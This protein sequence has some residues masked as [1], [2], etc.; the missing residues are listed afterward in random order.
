MKPLQALESQLDARSRREKILLYIALILGIYFCIFHSFFADSLEQ[1][2]Q[3]QHNIK[4]SQIYLQSNKTQNIAKDLASLQET[5]NKLTSLIET[6]NAQ[7]LPLFVTLKK[8]NNY[9]LEHRIALW[10]IDTEDEESNYR[11]SLMGN[12]PMKDLL[13]FLDF[14]ES[15]PLIHIASFEILDNQNFKLSL[16]NHSILSSLPPNSSLALD[17]VLEK[18]RVSLQ[19]EKLIFPNS[20]PLPEPANHA[21]QSILE[22]EALFNQ[23]AKINGQWFKEGESIEGYTL[24]SIQD[25]QVVLKSKDAVLKLQLKEKQ[26]FQ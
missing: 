5:H 4:Q 21:N 24:E 6:F 8:M 9:A 3:L 19:R 17:E 20:D 12:A 11:I 13:P 25:H 16:K 1:I 7:S 10:Q 26:L 2:R 22:L 15:L 14:L 23:K 18:I